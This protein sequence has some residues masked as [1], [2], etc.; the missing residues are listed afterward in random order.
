MPMNTL[1]GPTDVPVG[2]V[3]QNISGPTNSFK[4]QAIDTA[5]RYYFVRAFTN[6]GIAGTF[7]AGIAGHAIS[8]GGGTGTVTSV[9]LTEPVE[10]VVTGSPVTTS[11]TLAVTKASQTANTVWAGPTSGGAAQP[12]FRALVAADIPASVVPLFVDDEIVAGSGTAWTLAF[13]PSPALSLILVQQVSGFGGIVLI[14]GTDYTLA[15]AAV[16]T[17]NSLS[18]GVLRAWYRH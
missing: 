10:F 5:V 8:A 12:T 6:G 17:V 1:P 16:T 14:A 3:L 2:S 13:S 7:S 4:R 9:S 18:A 15:G 11:G